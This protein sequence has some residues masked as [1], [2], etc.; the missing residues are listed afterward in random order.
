LQ[1]EV[2]DLWSLFCYIRVSIFFG[3]STFSAFKA[4][5][6]T[7]ISF[8]MSKRCSY[9]VKG[10]IVWFRLIKPF[11]DMKFKIFGYCYVVFEP[12]KNFVVLHLAHSKPQKSLQLIW[13]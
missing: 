5:K 6:I 9:E 3:S 2:Q 7:P 4:T 8:E 11:S 12:Q 1:F 13:K 10:V